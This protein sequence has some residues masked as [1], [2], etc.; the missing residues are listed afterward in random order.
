MATVKYIREANGGARVRIGI[1]SDG[2][3]VAYNVSVGLYSSLGLVRGCE[4]D[5]ETFAEIRAEDE[6]YRAF[7]RA[8][9]LLSYADNTVKNLVMK[10]RRAGFSRDVA[11]ACAEEC[12]RLGYIDEERQI[13]RAALTEANR[14]LRG[15]EHIV[16]KLAA[17]GYK[18]DMVRD[19]IDSLVARG[20]IDFA[21]NFEMLAEKCRAVTD[22]ER[23]A[24]AYKRGYRGSDLD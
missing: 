4:F 12:L 9:G 11:E 2:D 20:D 10:L 7:K 15:K 23:R 14:S 17:K 13:E 5:D 24:L 1:L 22:E 19:V 18:R 21:A 8:L 16:Q 3:V 6:R